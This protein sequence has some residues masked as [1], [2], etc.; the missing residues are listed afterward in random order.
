MSTQVRHALTVDVEDW[1][2]VSAFDD[3]VDRAQ[4]DTYD[5][6]VVANTERLLDLFD[7]H[8]TRATFFT[9]GW[10]AERHP[11]LVATLHARGHEVASHGSDHHLVHGMTPETFAA[12]LERAR[13]ALEAASPAPVRGF[14][15]P[16]FSITRGTPWAYDVLREAGYAYSS[17]VFPVRHD[18]YGIPDFPRGP[19]R[20]EDG[21]GGAIWELPMTTWRVLGR[22]VPASGGGWLRLLPPAVIRRGLGQAEADGRP[23]MLYLHPWEIDPEQPRLAAASRMARFRHTVNLHRTADRLDALLGRYAFGAVEDVIEGLDAGR[24]HGPTER[25]TITARQPA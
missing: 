11:E 4:W 6:R 9:L 15:A 21:E 23:G 16:S 20:V 8:G 7:R 5:S 25:R 2:Q 13:R 17:S 1:Y 10:V 3:I 19:V 14:R 18:R 12:D 22:N 24:F